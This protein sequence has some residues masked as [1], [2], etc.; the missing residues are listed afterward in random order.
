MTVDGVWFGDWIYWPLNSRLVTTFN[1]TVI[2]DFHSLQTTTAHAKCF[3][4]FTRRFSVTDLNNWDSWTEPKKSS[5]HRFPY[6]CLLTTD[7]SVLYFST[8]RVVNSVHCCTPTVSV[9]TCLYAKAFLSNSCLY[10]LIKN[11]LPSN[12]LCFVNLFRDRYL[13]MALH[14][15]LY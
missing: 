12:G 11:L 10:L 15:T 6:N 2:D 7:L 4:S 1:Y 14:V 5:L 13:I 9:T 3:Q 8:D